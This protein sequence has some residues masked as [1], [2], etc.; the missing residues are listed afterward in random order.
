M[1]A[2]TLC[3]KPF[4][5]LAWPLMLAT[6]LILWH[7]P[8]RANADTF[9]T[10]FGG[11]GGYQLLY[12]GD[13]NGARSYFE[14]AH[15]DVPDDP[16]IL[17][18]LAEVAMYQHDLPKAD[19]YIS[20]LEDMHESVRVYWLRARRAHS[21]GQWAGALEGYGACAVEDMWRDPATHAAE[22]IWEELGDEAYARVL[23]GVATENPVAAAPLQDLLGEWRTVHGID[24]NAEHR[25]AAEP[26]DAQAFANENEWPAIEVAI[27]AFWD[28]RD[29]V[30]ADRLLQAGLAHYPRDNRAQT[31]YRASLL[32]GANFIP[33]PPA[34]RRVPGSEVG[35]FLAPDETFD[36]MSKFPSDLT[37][38]GALQTYWSNLGEITAVSSQYGNQIAGQLAALREDL[39]TNTA[40]GSCDA[41]VNN[42][43]Q[44]DNL[45]AQASGM[46]VSEQQALQS[47]PAPPGFENFHKSL[48]TIENKQLEIFD[49]IRRMIR[50]ADL[51][52]GQAALKMAQEDLPA[53]VDKS[54]GEFMSAYGRAPAE[55]R[56]QGGTE[57]DTKPSLK[58]EADMSD[59]ERLYGPTFKFDIPKDGDTTPINEDGN[60]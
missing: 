2:A 13:I 3:L 9:R 18:G 44:L 36:Y 7:V 27:N 54:I 30:A 8:Q 14:S 4:T 42:L 31:L 12:Q 48:Y 35:Q 38:G 39:K 33:V 58:A 23:D 26:W 45:T 32:R 20:Q 47:L 57:G 16:L 49:A 5:R 34:P 37:F 50:T 10:F 15:E 21:L 25:A 60:N 41:L 43:V 22:A 53:L 59:G 55:W 51:A 19:G 28:N 24:P 6:G 56:G 40:S 11:T 46:I 52:T 29:E 1:R 17:Q